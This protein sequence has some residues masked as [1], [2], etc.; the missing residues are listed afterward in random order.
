MLLVSALEISIFPPRGPVSG[1]EGVEETHAAGSK[2]ILGFY[3]A[4]CNEVCRSYKLQGF[5]YH[6]CVSEIFSHFF[7]GCTGKAVESD[8]VFRHTSDTFD[9]CMND[10]DEQ[11]QTTGIQFFFQLKAVPNPFCIMESALNYFH[12]AK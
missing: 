10:R 3:I 5:H 11:F 2:N 12:K 1:E 8:G 7:S 4:T 9:I 6:C